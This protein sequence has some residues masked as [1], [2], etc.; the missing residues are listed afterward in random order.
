MCF[1]QQ[2][3]TYSSS[4]SA[5][6]INVK[7][8]IPTASTGLLLLFISGLLAQVYQDFTSKITGLDERRKR[9]KEAKDSEKV[10]IQTSLLFLEGW[11]KSQYSCYTHLAYYIHRIG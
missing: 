4:F 7:T 2:Q 5:L 1:R 11:V 6:I 8:D 9:I 10:N 3:L